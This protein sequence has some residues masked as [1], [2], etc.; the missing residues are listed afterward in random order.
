MDASNSGGA[1]GEFQ[2]NDDT[3]TIAAGKTAT[4]IGTNNFDLGNGATLVNNGKFVAANN[5]T[6]DDNLGGNGVVN[7]KGSFIRNTGT[8][9]FTVGVGI[10]FNNSGMVNVRRKR[11]RCQCKAAASDGELRCLRFER[12]PAVH[13]K[14]HPGESLER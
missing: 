6:I 10:A 8:G 13:G 7:N 3:L 4:F 5:Q 12:R 2:L 11:E 1:F 9:I 14:L